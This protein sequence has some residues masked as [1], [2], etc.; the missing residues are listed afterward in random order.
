MYQ[1]SYNIFEML[2]ILEKFFQIFRQFINNYRYYLFISKDS[3]YILQVSARKVIILEE[4]K[5]LGTAATTGNNGLND[6]AN[7]T[8]NGSTND[9]GDKMYVSL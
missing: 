2:A 7:D 5:S 4:R 9:L 3:V 8:G 1:I 6:N